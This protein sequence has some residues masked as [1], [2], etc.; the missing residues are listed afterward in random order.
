M[1]IISKLSTAIGSKDERANIALAIQIAADENQSAIRELIE[2]LSNSKLQND[3]IKTLY[4]IGERNPALIAPYFPIFLKLLSSKNNR[5]QW[6]AMSAIYSIADENAAQIVD[7]LDRLELAAQQGT[8]ITRDNFVKTLVK[9]LRY[10]EWEEE[11]FQRLWK[12]LDQAPNNQFPMYAEQIMI[13]LPKR[14]RESFRAVLSQRIN[15]LP[16]ETQQKRIHKLLR[17]LG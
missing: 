2:N 16:K 13:E 17:N 3:C 5:L 8:V 14:F 7:S 15:D 9:L 10:A 1:S 11:I 4:E 12:Q 6:G